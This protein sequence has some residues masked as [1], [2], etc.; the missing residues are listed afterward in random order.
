MKQVRLSTAAV[1]FT[2]ALLLTMPAFATGGLD[3][4]LGEINVSARKDI[5]GFRTDLSVSSGQVNGLFEIFDSPADV[6]MTLRIGEVAHVKVDRVVEEYKKNQGQGWGAIAKNLGIKPGS[7]EFHALKE[8]RLNSHKG[9]GGS[10][11]PAS[12]K[13]KPK[14]RG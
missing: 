3:G 8:G 5:G 7:A 11:K 10:A 12:G 2:S 14:G 6:Y 4:F 13:G 1:V 9:S